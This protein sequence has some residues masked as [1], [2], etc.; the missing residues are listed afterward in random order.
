[1]PCVPRRTSQPPTCEGRKFGWFDKQ[2]FD[3][4]PS[5]PPIGVRLV[6]SGPGDSRLSST[7]RSA[8]L[9]DGTVRQL[10]AQCQCTTVHGR[11][12]EAWCEPK[13]PTT[14]NEGVTA[15]QRRWATRSSGGPTPC[16]RASGPSSRR[17]PAHRRVRGQCGSQASQVRRTSSDRRLLSTER[18]ALQPIST[19]A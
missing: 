14:E 11:I 18:R 8:Q 10:R 19:A 9:L 12:K 7:G 16:S 4:S 2:D 6:K 1:L 17:C 5:A 3:K 13:R 15:G